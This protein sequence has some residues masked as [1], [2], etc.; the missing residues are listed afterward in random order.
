MGLFRTVFC[1]FATG[2][3]HPFLSDLAERLQGDWKRE[4]CRFPE[5]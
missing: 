1:L 2:F 5:R 4:S 3:L